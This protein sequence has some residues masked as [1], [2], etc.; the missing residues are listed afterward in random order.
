M[1]M[2][3]CLHGVVFSCPAS[4]DVALILELQTALC[5]GQTAVTRAWC[6]VG[7]FSEAGWIMA[8]CWRLPLRSPPVDLLPSPPAAFT[9]KVNQSSSSSKPAS[10]SIICVWTAHFGCRPYCML[11][12]YYAASV[13]CSLL[14]DFLLE[15]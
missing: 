7:V 6:R 8:G 15:P 12:L 10:H 11:K 3:H 14:G 4:S 5:E 9:N 2:N 1:L 13:E